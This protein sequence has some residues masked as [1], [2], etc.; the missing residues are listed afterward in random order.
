MATATVSASVEGPILVCDERPG[1]RGG[2]P[3][4]P[5]V[6]VRAHP[7]QRGRSPAGHTVL[8]PT[9]RGSCTGS[10]VLPGLACAGTAPPAWIAATP[11]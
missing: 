11:G 1:V 9:G 10:G 8:M 3:P 6:S 5:G 2:A 4:A 7:P